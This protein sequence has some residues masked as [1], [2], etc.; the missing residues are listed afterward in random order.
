[1]LLRVRRAR[2]K[3]SASAGVVEAG[4][5]CERPTEGVAEGEGGRTAGV[6]DGVGTSSSS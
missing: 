6:V 3:V 4:G 1:M 2:P 5:G